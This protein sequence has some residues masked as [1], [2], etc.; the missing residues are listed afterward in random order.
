MNLPNKLKIYFDGSC[1]PKNPGGVAGYGW[2]ITDEHD[3]QLHA[4]HGEVCRGAGATNNIAE[5]GG[6]TKALQYLKQQGWSGELEIVGDSELV[7]N[8]VRGIYRVK[9][10]TLVPYHQECMKLLGEW[11]W[12]AKWISREE[13]EKCDQLSKRAWGHGRIAS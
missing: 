2:R 4:E 7:I 8:Q 9:K 12:S 5:W 6:L 13:N 11:N 10:E 3:N 1:G